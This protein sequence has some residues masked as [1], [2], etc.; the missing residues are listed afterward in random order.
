M[1]H[2]MVRCLKI[3]I[4]SDDGDAC[5]ELFNELSMPCIHLKGYEVS[6]F[7]L[8]QSNAHLKYATNGF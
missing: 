7:R 4:V 2:R 3:R 1:C 8:P 5:N 6:E